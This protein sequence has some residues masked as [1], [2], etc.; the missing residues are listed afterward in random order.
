MNCQRPTIYL[1]HSATT[2]LHPEVI[3]LLGRH[4][5]TFG[6]PSS[7]H[8]PGEEAR[9][10]VEQARAQVAALVH[11]DP[12]E[13]VFTGSGTEADN[14]AVKGIAFA[15]GALAGQPR[16]FCPLTRVAFRWW[17][18]LGAWLRGPVH[19]I[20]SAI[21]HS[22]VLASCRF[23]E[24]LGHRV[25]YVGVGADGR[26]D[27]DDVRRHLRANTRLISIMHANNE[28]G[29]VQPIEEIAVLAHEA[30][31]LFHTDA[32]QTAGKIPLDLSELPADLITLSAQK[33]YGP[34]GVGAL[35]VRGGTAVEPLLHG[36]GQEH[37][38]RAGTENVLG[39][40]GFGL[41]CELAAQA[42][43]AEMDRQRRLRDRLRHG[44]LA[45]GDVRVNGDVGHTLPG[46]L[47]VSFKN[48][49]GDALA[50]ALALEGI[51]V[52]TGSACHTGKHSHVLEAMGVGADW[53]QG[54]VRF[55]LGRLTTAAQ[56]ER[57]LAVVPRL[58]AR[59]QRGSLPALAS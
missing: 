57:V 3:E 5:C 58:I 53:L 30:G 19:I 23:L 49:R 21:E 45:L 25:T 46:T 22:A 1:D 12:E 11:A 17:D 18:G 24:T 31:V 44:L 36:G 55:S 10:L 13:I 2:P 39:I 28:T 9:G 33:L 14:L 16:G 29:V 32:C 54:A 37:G 50:T 51:A 15:S 40:I 56:I 48:I 20:T 41:A 7:Q 8:S 43:P 27:P 35:V 26:V 4:L 59:L 6:N 38:L 34:K 52:S 47:N 42:P